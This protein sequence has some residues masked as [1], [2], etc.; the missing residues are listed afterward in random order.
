VWRSV[1]GSC[2]PDVPVVELLRG[3]KAELLPDRA[4]FTH[5]WD[6]QRFATTIRKI[7]NPN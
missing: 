1:R 2:G 6:D 3:G 4:L 5:E 7:L